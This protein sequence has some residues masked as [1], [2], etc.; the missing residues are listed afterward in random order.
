MIISNKKVFLVP[1]IFG[2]FFMLVLIARLLTREEMTQA[3][4]IGNGLGF[5]VLLVLVSWSW[6]LKLSYRQLES[7]YGL[8]GFNK[9]RV[10]TDPEYVSLYT[11]EVDVKG[12]GDNFTLC[13]GIKLASRKEPISLLSGLPGGDDS[14]LAEFARQVAEVTG[15]PVKESEHFTQVFKHKFGKAFSLKG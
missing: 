9:V 12:T 13:I 6:E 3:A 14:R 2:W 7:R 15:L 10:Y 11:R 1:R 5:L 4:M 8:P